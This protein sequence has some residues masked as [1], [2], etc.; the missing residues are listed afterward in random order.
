VTGLTIA[1]A[2]GAC[3][4][5]QSSQ[6]T[7]RAAASLAL[8]FEA[9][10]PAALQLSLSAEVLAFDLS[11]GPVGPD[12]LA[13]RVSDVADDP[14]ARGNLADPR[15]LPADTTFRPTVWPSIEVT[16]GSALESYP[17]PPG[18]GRIICY[19]S[20]LA[21]PFASV[22]SWSLTA[23]RSDL[24]GTPPLDSVYVGGGC[25]E[26]EVPG[27]APLPAQSA[28]RLAASRPAAP[29]A[30]DAVRLVVAVDVTAQA[31]TAAATT[32]RYTLMAS[33]AEFDQE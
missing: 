5:A 6:A 1:I 23:T 22:D 28:V 18:A 16:G 14:P 29:R 3:A 2:V 24:P 13:C 15:V 17:P 31:T 30:C 7:G 12:G 11:T 8:E 27:L 32:V 9:D 25:R 4:H 20:F 33:D 21:R 19:R 10:V 26:R